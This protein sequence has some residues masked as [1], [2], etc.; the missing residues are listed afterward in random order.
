MDQMPP[1]VRDKFKAGMAA[2]LGTLAS[3]AGIGDAVS[4]ALVD[5]PSGRAMDQLSAA[6]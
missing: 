4:L 5:A 6:P 3:E 2:Q 1:F